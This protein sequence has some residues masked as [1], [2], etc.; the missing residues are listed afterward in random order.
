[1]G[2]TK[3]RGRGRPRKRETPLS[4]WIDAATRTREDVA[5]E[6]GVTRVH[7]D[8]LCRNERRPSLELALAIE[9][10]TAGAVPATFWTKVPAHSGD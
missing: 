6:L 1:M 5:E 9:K 10:L 4:R 2:K 3:K 8:R 7:L